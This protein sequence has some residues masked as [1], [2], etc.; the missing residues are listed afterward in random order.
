M[1]YLRELVAGQVCQIIVIDTVT[2]LGEVIH[3][4]AEMLYEA[5]NWTADGRLVL[6]GDGRLWQL[7]P[8]AGAVP[9]L[10]SLTGV[11]DLNN[12]HVLSPVSDEVFVSA[13]DWQIYVVPLAGGAARRLTPDDDG[14]MHFLHGVSPDGATLAYIGVQPAAEP[15]GAWGHG[16]VY[17]LET[18]G[19]ESVAL[20][21]DSW[22]SDG[23]EYSPDGAWL[24]LNTEAF[25]SQDG[26]AQI[27]RMP[28]GGGDLE[29]LTCDER[30]NWFPHVSPDGRSIVY[31][32][33]PSG[34]VGHP[35]DLPVE[36][37]LVR[38]GDWEAVETL[39]TLFGGQ[40]TI[41]VNSWAPDGRRLAFVAYPIRD[42]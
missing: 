11:P 33:Y 27:A 25:S 6:N 37:R 34:T 17:V 12:D 4:S 18:G 42:I 2:G 10:I 14:R 20:T 22:S 15:G 13:N 9:E 36:L 5:P 39:A 16:V 24:Y 32:S 40:G 23:C 35:A 29:Q 26:H 7:R 31:L 3:E 1:R 19:V 28:A 30:V 41:N 8:Q 21:S 38:D